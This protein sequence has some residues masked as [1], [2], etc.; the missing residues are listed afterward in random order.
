METPIFENGI[1]AF[2]FPYDKAVDLTHM[3]EIAKSIPLK[4]PKC[5]ITC[6]A[7]AVEEVEALRSVVHRFALT[8]NRNCNC[9]RDMSVSK[10][11]VNFANKEL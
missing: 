7:S 11:Y 10:R 4:C 5:G 9:Y 1:S 6:N 3:M 2:T 8:F